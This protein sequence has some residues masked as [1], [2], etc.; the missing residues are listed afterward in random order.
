MA[1]EYITITEENSLA[2]HGI[3]G[4]K[5]GRKNGPPYPLDAADHSA[6]EKR[7]NKGH[8]SDDPDRKNA[9]AP[10]SSGG[11]SHH[12][13]SGG[14]GGGSSSKPKENRNNEQKPET[15]KSEYKEE[16]RETS[17]IPRRIFLSECFTCQ[18]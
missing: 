9:N 10:N 14:G 4:Q 3:L 5:W 1:D 13:H 7:L 16:K 2:H 17:K 18:S 11:S 8:Y 6:K 12:G 15:S